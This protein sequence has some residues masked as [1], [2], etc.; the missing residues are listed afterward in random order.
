MAG[1][2]DGGRYTGVMRQGQR[3]L[4]TGGSHRGVTIT[5]PWKPVMAEGLPNGTL[6]DRARGW[7]G[8]RATAQG[9][10]APA[11]RA[12]PTQGTAQRT[13]LTGP[14]VCVHCPTNTDV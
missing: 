9:L 5:V 4:S 10:H 1:R 2:C 3:G 6:C 7:A 11:P 8:R 12:H 14:R 13:G